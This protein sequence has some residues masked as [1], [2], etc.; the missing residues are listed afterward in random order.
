[1][2]IPQRELYLLS[3]DT[4]HAAPH[5]HTATA[6]LLT[7]IH[8]CIYTHT[9][10]HRQD[11]SIPHR[12]SLIP[13]TTTPQHTP[14][15]HPRSTPAPGLGLA[16]PRQRPREDHRKNS[17]T[18]RAI[19]R[20]PARGRGVSSAGVEECCVCCTLCR[21]LYGQ[22]CKFGTDARWGV[23]AVGGGAC[24]GLGWDGAVGLDTVCGVR[25]LVFY[26]G[27]REVRV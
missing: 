19:A 5:A 21:G 13:I 23:L 2:A 9:R 14:V 27:W 16:C 3:Q 18:A 1:M 24:V 15:A 22:E 17:T 10:T 20:S 8:T 7:K 6:A 12:P 26:E 4:S 25:W 11:M